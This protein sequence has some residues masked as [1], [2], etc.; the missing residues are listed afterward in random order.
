MK[1]FLAIMLVLMLTS[2]VAFAYEGGSGVEIGKFM[3]SIPC[4][5]GG[6]MSPLGGGRPDHL[7]PDTQ[8]YP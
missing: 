8:L 5:G 1:K 6:P 3:N 2:A 4:G 7:A